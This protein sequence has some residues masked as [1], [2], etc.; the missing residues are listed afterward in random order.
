MTDYDSR[1]DTY[2]HIGRVR[3]YLTV[4]VGKLLDRASVHDASKLIE[5]ELEAFDRMTPLLASLTYGTQAYK[6]SLTELGVALEHHYAS[7]THHPE[8]YGDGIA[9]MSLLDL[10][11][12]LV[13][14]KAASERMR[15]PMPAAPGRAEAPQYSD[16][17]LNSITLNQT[18]FGYTDELRTILENTARELG[19]SATGADASSKEGA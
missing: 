7:N 5:P 2:E 4:C 16:D 8:H 12:M 15:K 3:H 6:D 17:F 10:L 18:R 1:P 14:W 11:E 13:D 19:F 9:G